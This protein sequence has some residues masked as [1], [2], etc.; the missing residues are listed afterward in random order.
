MESKS[1]GIVSRA[2]LYADI[3]MYNKSS[4]LGPE[5]PPTVP[6]QMFP[7]FL[8]QPVHNS[9]D[10]LTYDNSLYNYPSVQS[11]YPFQEPKYY[12]GKCPENNMIREF[13]FETIKE[14]KTPTPIPKSCN[15]VN[16]PIREGYT[17]GDLKDLDIV[18]FI[19]K[20]CPFSKEQLKQSFINEITIK[21]VKKKENKQMLTNMGGTATPY[22]YSLKTNKFYTGLEKNLENLYKILSQKETFMNESQQ[23]VKELDIIIYSSPNCPYCVKLKKMLQDEGMMEHVSLIEDMSKM[24]NLEQIQGF[25]YLMSNKTSKNMTGCPHSMDVLIE[26]LSID[27]KGRTQL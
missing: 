19:D 18:L 20:K 8:E 2:S 11:A 1:N 3:D 6:S 14:T 15:V 27:T 9:Y 7:T 24:K 22:F 10:I 4:Q 5:L 21:D 16:E 23:K 25:P 26:Q 13:N 17:S 12:V